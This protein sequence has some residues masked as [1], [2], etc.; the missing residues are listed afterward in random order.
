[1]TALQIRQAFLDFFVSKGHTIV[2]SAPIVIKNDPTLMFTNAGMN[3]FKD[4]FLGEAPAKAP[5]V[6]D[7]QRCLRV[8]G[9]HND[10]E[11]V[12]IDTYHHTMFEMLGNWSFGDYFKKEAIAWG[13][14]LLTEVYKLPKDRL[15]ITYFEGDEKDGLEKDTETYEFWKALVAE[16]HILRGNKKDNFWEM[17]ETG[18]CGPC[19]EIHF[20]SRPDSE[21][22]EVD[23]ASLVNA[24]HD[25]VIEVWNIVFMQFNR[26]KS[27]AL[28]SL[29][30]KHVDTGMGFERLVRVLQGKTSNYDTDVFQP[31]IQFIAE[32]SGKKYNS[33]AKP[34]DADWNE[35]V[36]MR[37]LADHI[38]A[39]SFAIADGQLPASNKA[40]YVIRRIL[41]RAVRYSYQTL[42]F[43][44]PFFNQLV[45][46]LA[47]QFK[48]VFD[49]LYSQKDFVQ[50]V[51]LEEEVSFL[52]TLQSGISRFEEFVNSVIP[53]TGGKSIDEIGDKWDEFEKAF[54]SK[55]IY[56]AF[57]FELQDTFGFPIDLTE[58]MAREKGWTVDMEG[59]EAALQAQKSRSRAATAIDT[60]DWVILK[61]DE[62]VEFTG[63]DETETIAHVVKYRKVTAKGKE[64]YQI[65][66]DKT[67]FY[68][69]SGGQVG[70]KGELVF[71]D[72]EIVKVTDT[73][74]ENG[75]IVHFVD[76]LPEDIDDA[77][78]AIVD[79]ALRSQ[80]NSNHS[81]THLLHAAMKQVLGSHVNQKGSLVNADYL[82]F[83]FSHFAKVT[84]EELAQIEA[85]VNQKVRQN[86]PLKEERSV[87]Y[88]EAIQ[89]G[90]TALFGEKYGE[91][92]RVITFDDEFSKEL[93]G[94]THVKATGQIG[95]FKI[96]A[97]SAVAAGVRRIEAITGVAAEVYINE[98]SNL[99]NQL[100]ELLK[101][102]KNIPKSV[103]GLLDE[104]NK[105]KKEIEKSILEKSSGLKNELA[106]K[107]KEIGDVNFIA[108]KV[109]LPNAD[110]VKN[111]AY[112]L[113]DIVPNLFLVLAADFDGK[114]SLTVMIAENLVKEKGLHAGNIVKE[115]AKEVKGG[116]GG[117]P[118]FATAGG[119]D[120]TG[121][122]AALAKAKSFVG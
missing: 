37:V 29:P 115:L 11:E 71:P 8:S 114:P 46:L 35:A 1:M 112:Q 26:L 45:P 36:A 57:A 43:K 5:R 98:Q 78:T 54:K 42:G 27:G 64:Q 51:V 61:Y 74:K 108:Q 13:W 120:V 119:S 117:Q 60:G 48:G 107:A 38:R 17:G 91:Y 84:D 44:E 4:I 86:I 33:A 59:F 41:R 111:L 22:A 18:P 65:V 53:F 15:Y 80:T 94:G 49:N 79:P 83:D 52:R 105:L 30:N 121:L 32:K 109:A 14:E 77:L 95:F 21:R 63:Y 76:K 58:L 9:K 2:P 39:I 3:Q 97:E 103:E 7:T 55:I 47:E 88:A 93:C 6:A 25:Q 24:D 56:G 72:G 69:E 67:P 28:Q 75:L 81:A 102:P 85:I 16:D 90:V 68:A 73:K 89:S 104:N 122:D 31:M 82:R 106:Q 92:V 20:D 34:G 23:G 50:K 66:L 70:D 10:L 12:G 62:S 99:V 113:K 118:F 87:L 116:G 96:I 101:N 100:K 110:A 40:G 19:S